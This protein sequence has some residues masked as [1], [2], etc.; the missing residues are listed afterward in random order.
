MKRKPEPPPEGTLAVNVT[1]DRAIWA[2]VQQLA[3][4][5]GQR[6]TE[7][8]RGQIGEIVKERAA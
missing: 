5:V 2:K 1:F 8:V 6:P 7:W 3:R 4:E